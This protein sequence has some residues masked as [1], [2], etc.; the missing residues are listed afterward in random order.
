[1]TCIKRDI[2]PV[3]AD[4]DD[5]VDKITLQTSSNL[6]SKGNEPPMD[7][8]NWTK[9]LSKTDA[10]QETNGG[11]VPYLRLTKAS[12]KD[13]DFQTWFRNEFFA[14]ADWQKG[15]F[16]R[17]DNIELAKII[18]SVTFSKVFIGD[19]VFEL[20]HGEDRWE[21]NNTPNTW[22]HWPIKIQELLSLNDLS[23]QPVTLIRT[24]TGSFVME[25]G[26]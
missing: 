6:P 20:S 21:S 22:L 10:Q 12:L 13:E 14:G 18:V 9:K 19:I 26:N 15:S 25:L 7:K 8:P 24:G 16:G 1:M 17:D 3:D 23:G 11:L 2:E 4:F 5:V